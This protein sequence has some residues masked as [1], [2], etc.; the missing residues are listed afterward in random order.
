[1]YKHPAVEAVAVVAMPD[2][3]W[4]ETPC[5]FVQIKEN[6]EASENELSQW[7]RD[8]MASFKTP[9]KFIFDNIPK[10]STGKVQKFILRAQAIKSGLNKT[11]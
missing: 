4:G 2:E 3:K 11:A 5:A 8:N 6:S 7:C 1:M 10:T 9:R